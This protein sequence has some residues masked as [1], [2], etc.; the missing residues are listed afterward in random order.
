MMI[1]KGNTY[2]LVDLN[3]I[4]TS[5]KETKILDLMTCSPNE[6]LPLSNAPSRNIL[7]TEEI[8]VRT[9]LDFLQVMAKEFSF[10]CLQG[11]PSEWTVNFMPRMWSKQFPS[12]LFRSFRARGHSYYLGLYQSMDIYILFEPHESDE[13]DCCD[14]SFAS[15]PFNF[16]NFVTNKLIVPMLNQ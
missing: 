1:I 13:S 11:M 15:L 16:G 4:V 8:S 14:S 12:K 5:L 3:D 2:T 6:R 7:P 10:E 9:Y